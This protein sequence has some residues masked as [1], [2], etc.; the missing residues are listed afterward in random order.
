MNEL[1]STTGY[2]ESLTDGDDGYMVES[3]RELHMDS[4]GADDF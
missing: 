2:N 3:G 1:L 4:F